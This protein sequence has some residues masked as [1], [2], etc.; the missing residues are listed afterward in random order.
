MNSNAAGRRGRTQFCCF[1][2]RW[3]CFR[4]SWKEKRNPPSLSRGLV[5]PVKLK[6]KTLL[7]NCCHCFNS[8]Q[9]A[10]SSL[11]PLPPS[12]AFLLY[13]Y[14]PLSPLCASPPSWFPS[15]NLF[16][17]SKA[18]FSSSALLTPLFPLN[19]LL[20]LSP[21]PS[22][23]S[24]L[25]ILSLVAAGLCSLSLGPS[26]SPALPAADLLARLEKIGAVFGS[27]KMLLAVGEGTKRAP[28]SF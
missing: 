23:F 5:F 18:P 10:T 11:S 4:G 26:A 15:V 3:P 17:F 19:S 12:S 24:S 28:R 8:P 20:R 1:L 25:G 14:L 16:L 22:S 21:K 27:V 13:F 7:L 2:P 9:L 6:D